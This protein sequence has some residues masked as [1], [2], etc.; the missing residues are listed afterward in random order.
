MLRRPPLGHVLA[1]AH[2]IHRE[3]RIVSTLASTAVPV[4][5]AIDLIDDTDTASITGTPFF[6]L[7]FVDGRVLIH[8]AQNPAFTEAGIRVLSLELASD[9]ARL[10]TLDPTTLEL[11]DFGRADGYLERQLRTWRTTEPAPVGR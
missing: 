3:H 11:D 4:P 7:G 1:S 6:V 10:H 9:L 5:A 2:D 8:R